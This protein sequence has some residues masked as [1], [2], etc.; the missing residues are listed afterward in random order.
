MPDARV[1]RLSEHLWRLELAVDTLPPYDHTNAYLIADAGVGVLVDPGAA[2]DAALGVIEAA[3]RR[4]QVNLLKGIVLTHAHPDHVAVTRIVEDARFDAKLRKIDLPG[5]PI[6]P[7][8]MFYYYATHLRWVANPNFLIDVT[9]YLEQKIVA[10]RAY[11]TQ[12]VRANA[13]VVE[14]VEA[15]T[16]YM[17]SRLGVPAAEAF[18]TK[19][20][21]GLAG[22]DGLV[23]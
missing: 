9:G 6:Y 5:E 4:A 10:I 20:P 22:L 21:I 23:I 7:R 14:W 8:W 11:E 19:E 1:E 3:L 12:F 2:D 13:H 18:Y 15:G 17:G 16:K